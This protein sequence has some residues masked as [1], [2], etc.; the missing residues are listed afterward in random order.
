[1]SVGGPATNVYWRV[2]G[3]HV[4]GTNHSLSQVILDAR[5]ALYENNLTIIPNGEGISGFFSCTV[6]N[7]RGNGSADIIIPGT[8]DYLTNQLLK[9][10]LLKNWAPKCV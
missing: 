6:H 7:S 2:N 8:S 4:T 9:T 3:A 5:I 10:L 1:M